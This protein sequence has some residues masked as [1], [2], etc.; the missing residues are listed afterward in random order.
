MLICSSGRFRWAYCQLD[1]LG[2]CPPG[3]IR[4]ALDELPE[5]LDATYERTLEDINDANWE[6]ARRLLQCVAV[7]SRPLRVEELAEFLAFDFKGGLIPK[8]H[9]DWRLEDPVEAVLSTCSTLLALVNV[10]DSQVIQFSHFSVKEFLISSRFAEKHNALSRR[11]HISLTI[12][13]M[14][15][16]QAC[17][18]IIL[19]LDKNITR[20]SL[21][22]FPLTKYAAEHWFEHVRF[23]GVSQHAVEGMKELFDERKPHFGIWLWIWD[24][25][26]PPW[27]QNTQAGWPLPPCGT[28]LHYA[29]FCGLHGIIKVLA[30]EKSQDVNSRNFRDELTPLHLASQEGHVEVARFLVEQGADATAQAKDGRTPLHWA[31]YRGHIALARLLV[32]HGVD[33]TIQAKDGQTQLHRAS[34]GGRMELARFLVEHGAEVTA[35]DE[36]W[37]TP[38]HWASL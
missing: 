12:A 30:T 4:H 11:Y 10:E 27:H 35:Q 13:H 2:K 1:Y 6:F 33:V 31:S 37:W 26:L 29:A 21:D 36:D 9:E 14:L 15:V 18:G 28:P 24:P 22:K 17:L 20:D 19:H 25:T 3:C 5:T 16:A 23:E 32:E 34:E 8:Y 38:L 7:V